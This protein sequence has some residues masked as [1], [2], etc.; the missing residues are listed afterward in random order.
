MEGGEAYRSR[1][2]AAGT[3]G[4]LQSVRVAEGYPQHAFAL[5]QGATEVILV[6]H[7]AS[8]PALPGTPFPLVEGQADP[9]LS[10]EGELQAA[11]LVERLAGEPLTGLFVTT[12]RR[13]QATAAAFAGRLGLEPVVVPEL[14]EVHLGDFE[15]GEWRIRVAQGDPV[16]AQV[17]AEQRWDAV[18][19]AEPAERFAARVRSGLERVVAAVGPNTVAA[20][21]THGGVI[22]ELCR[23]A[24]DSRPLA[25]VHAD[26]ASLTRLVVLPDNRWLLR[27]FND[28]AHLT[29]HAGS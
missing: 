28:T 12:L 15:G 13:T 14:R 21:V 26:N 17:F 1:A 23:Q 6:R 8:E 11:A 3:I 22:G 24:T 18:P 7:G 29:N 4:F 16:V 5:P 20:A 27:S 2:H 9:G 19:N 10:P 25:F